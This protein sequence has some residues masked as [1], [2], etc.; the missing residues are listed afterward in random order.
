MARPSRPNASWAKSSI[1]TTS[2]TRAKFLLNGGE[3]GRQLGILTAGTY[4]INTA[5]FTVIT[6]VHGALSTA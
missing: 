3:K 6:G 1:A 2:R 5:L 4:R